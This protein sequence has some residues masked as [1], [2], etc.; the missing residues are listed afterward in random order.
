MSENCTDKIIEIYDEIDGAKLIKEVESNGE[1][2]GIIAWYGGHQLT[3]LDTYGNEDIRNV[4]DFYYPTISKEEAQKYIEEWANEI[5][6][7]WE[8]PEEE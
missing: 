1:V 8:N 6:K 3:F 7:E 2:L 5:I 4:G